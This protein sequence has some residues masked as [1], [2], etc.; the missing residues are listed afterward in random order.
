LRILVHVTLT[1]MLRHFE[2]VLLS[3]ADRGHTVRIASPVRKSKAPPLPALE[4]HR[5]V[6]FITAPD[7]RSDEWKDRVA[8]LRVL[9]DYL[10][11][12]E[13]RFAEAPKLRARAARKMAHVT[14]HGVWGHLV[15]RCPRCHERLFD[16]E[17][18]RMLH[19]F[20]HAG[21]TNIAA[22]LAATESIIPSDSG[23]DAF[24][25]EQ[26]PDVLLITPLIMIGSHQ[27]DFVKSAKALGVPV[28]FPVFSWDN[29]STKGLVH[30]LPDRV[31]VWNDRQRQEAIEMHY[32][33][34]QAIEVTGA[35]RFDDFFAMRP[36]MSRQRFCDEYGFDANQPIV[37][38]LCSS[39]FVARNKWVEGGR[40]VDFVR[41]WVD[42]LRQDPSLRTC[43]ILVR[44]HP[45]ERAQWK[46]FEAP[47]RVAVALPRAMNADP[48]L[49]E[50]LHH[51]A[52]GVGLN[53]SAQL[54][55]AVAGKPVLT[56]LVP[57]FSAGQQGTLHFS[58]LLKEQGGFVELAPDMETHVR[59]LA[60][61]V[62]GEYDPKAIRRFVES[63]LRPRGV[64]RPA[65]PIMVEAIE[66]LV[67]E[68]R[69]RAAAGRATS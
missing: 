23:L 4:A 63:F 56:V 37:L 28:V 66:A 46:G 69:A 21:L 43:N 2:S 48:S 5:N 27:P 13:P 54:E 38:Y 36:Q 41:K 59:Q 44:P 40:E 68:R 50:A 6:S 65:S 18:G 51:S 3:L 45:R 26:A 20:R 47:E 1:T 57:E 29:L 19:G 16:D 30:V 35:P 55:A 60:A 58:Y 25:R 8:D 62:A 22:L 61:A 64:D 14:T 39:E 53:T 17:V 11:Y 7:G 15:A 42:R 49:F 9:R 52:V 67:V 32:V 34:E 24:L 10:R 31:L 12:L 33:P